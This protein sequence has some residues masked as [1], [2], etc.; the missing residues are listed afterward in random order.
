MVNRLVAVSN[1][2]TSAI[3]GRDAT[4]LATIAP[5]GAANNPPRSS[6]AVAKVKAEKP[7]VRMK[8]AEMVV[9]KKN[10][11]VLTVPIVTRRAADHPRYDEAPEQ[12]P[13]DVAVQD[14]AGSRCRR[15][16]RFDEVDARRCERR[17]HAKQGHQKRTHDDAE[18]H[19]EGAIDQLRR[20]A[21]GDEGQKRLKREIR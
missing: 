4:R 16:E 8:V 9:V 21:D 6:P 7:I 3:N 12:L 13:V 19:P 10:S 14:V 20:E 1:T 15:R 18:R 17:R 11:A 2:P 5:S